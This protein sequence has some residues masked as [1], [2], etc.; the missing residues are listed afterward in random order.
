MIHFSGAPSSAHCARVKAPANQRMLQKRDP[1]NGSAVVGF[2][3]MEQ[4]MGYPFNLG[5]N[6]S[7]FLFTFRTL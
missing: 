5:L 6:R 4:R 2:T 3:G 1:T 7:E